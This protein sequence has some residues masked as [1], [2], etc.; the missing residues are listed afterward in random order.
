MTLCVIYFFF[1]YYIHTLYTRN[2]AGVHSLCVYP[3]M[4][5]IENHIERLVKDWFDFHKKPIRYIHISRA[6]A[7]Y[8]KKNNTTA[9]AVIDSMRD[10]KRI[11]VIIDSNACRWIVMYS[12]WEKLDQA[13]RIELCL[14]IFKRKVRAYGNKPKLTEQPMSDY[15]KLTTK[16]VSEF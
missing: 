7:S 6:I 8:C 4:V 16:K 2:V 9:L 1:Y 5:S 10:S 14:P 13:G 12:V 15:L 3:I 11:H